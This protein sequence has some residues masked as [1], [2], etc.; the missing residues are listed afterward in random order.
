M[1]HIAR[2][3][4][5]PPFLV[6]H[7]ADHPDNTAQAFR[8]GAALKAAGVPVKIVAAKETNHTRINANLGVDGDPC[9]KDLFA[10]V[11]NALKQ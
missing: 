7:V 8:L 11:D 4:G 2:G 1:T 6:L 5:I 3:K 9:T 10:F